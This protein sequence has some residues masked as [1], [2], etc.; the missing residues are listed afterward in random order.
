MVFSGSVTRAKRAIRNKIIRKRK[1]VSG[2]KRNE[3]SL[4]IARRLF[5]LDEFI[6]SKA[7]LCF[8]SLPHEVQTDAIIWESF[9]LNKEVFAPLISDGQEGLQI[10]RVSSLDMEFVVGKFGVWEPAPDAREI[11][12]PS[13]VD[14][15]VVPGLAFDVCGNRIGYGGGYYDRL[16]TDLYGDVTHIGIGYDFQVLDCVPRSN[17]DKSVQ[18][19]ITENKTFKCLSTKGI[20]V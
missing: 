17:L 5:E 10:S 18:F 14:F 13:S 12:S 19:V 2:T 15:V 7:V 1:V 3:K 11:V 16:L 6:K 4:A 9:R 20:G 8:L